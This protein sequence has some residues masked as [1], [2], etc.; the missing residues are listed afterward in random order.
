MQLCKLGCTKSYFYRSG[1]QAPQE[2]Y[3][4]NAPLT[5]HAGSRSNQ[6]KIY[7]AATRRDGWATWRVIERM[8]KYWLKL[9]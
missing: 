7:D 8:E 6:K 1:S 2:S 3:S 4:L 9:R 5:P